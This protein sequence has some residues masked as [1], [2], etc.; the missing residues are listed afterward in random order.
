[1]FQVEKGDTATVTHSIIFATA[2]LYGTMNEGI[3]CICELWVLISQPVLKTNQH[4]LHSKNTSV[5]IE[6]VEISSR[7]SST[8]PHIL[9]YLPQFH[10]F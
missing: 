8:I 1:M 2:D 6:I 5:D 4:L 7:L 3:R 9:D 10:S